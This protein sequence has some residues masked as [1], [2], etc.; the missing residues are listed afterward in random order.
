MVIS[1]FSGVL[2]FFLGIGEVFEFWREVN[3]FCYE[4]FVIF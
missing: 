1:K 3:N 4:N 2:E